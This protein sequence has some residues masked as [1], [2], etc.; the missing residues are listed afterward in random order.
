MAF[1]SCFREMFLNLCIIDE[2]DEN[3]GFDHDHDDEASYVPRSILQSNLSTSITSGR[4]LVMLFT[5]LCMY[6][7]AVLAIVPNTGHQRQC[8]NG[9]YAGIRDANKEV[10]VYF[11]RVRTA[12][13]S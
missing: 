3:P 5:Q 12:S 11:L 10:H 4:E 6:R 9:G 8:Y 7:E 13:E 2:I 1:N